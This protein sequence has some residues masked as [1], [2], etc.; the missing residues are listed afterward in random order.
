MK[1]EEHNPVSFEEINAQHAIGDMPAMPP[2][3]GQDNNP[4]AGDNADKGK[5]AGEGEPVNWEARFKEAETNYAKEKET[6]LNERKSFEQKIAEYEKKPPPI[7]HK[8]SDLSRLEV[9]R[10]KSPEKFPLYTKLLF[11]NPDAADLWKMDFVEKNPEYKDDPETVQMMLEAEFE[12]FF[13]GTDKDEKE[14]KIAENRLKIAGNQIKAA[15]LAEFKA[16]E[17]SDPAVAEQTLKQQREALAKSWEVPYAELTKNPLK[18]A[19]KIALDDKS[20]VE[21]DFEPQPED[22]KKYNEAMGLFIL[23]NN[24]APTAENAEKARNYAIGEVLRE[25]FS[26]ILKATFQKELDR[27]FTEWQKTR[28]NNRPLN[29]PGVSGDGKKTQDQAILEMLEHGEAYVPNT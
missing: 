24:L 9:V 5:S 6:Y 14:F 13:D 23:H 1:P 15:K 29:P 7:T 28:N 26:D 16:I 3:E 17:V 27:R 4:P 8:D 11:G 12:H 19:Q 22:S 18:V 20:E 10:E 2:A 21:V 25:K